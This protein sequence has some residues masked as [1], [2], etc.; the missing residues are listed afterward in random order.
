M[1]AR[2]QFRTQC[3]QGNGQT[4]HILHTLRYQEMYREREANVKICFVLHYMSSV[5][6]V[7]LQ[8]GNVW[9]RLCMDSAR[10]RWTKVV[11]RGDA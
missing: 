10:D 4:N 2:N 1:E 8:T 5:A 6:L 7:G 3:K 9:C 11:E